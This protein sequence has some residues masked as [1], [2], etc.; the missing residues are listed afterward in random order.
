[1]RN[2]VPERILN[3]IKVNKLSDRFDCFS[4]F[5]D[6]SGFT[7]T[8]EALMK[9]GQEGAEVLSDILRYLFDTTVKA[10]YDHGGYVTKYAG[11]AFT[12]IFELKTGKGSVAANVLQAAL[13]TNNFFEENKIY[14]SRFGDFEFGVK[15]GIGYGECVCGIAGS[16]KEKT[17]YFSG[18]AVDLCAM[19]EHNAEKGQIWASESAF[20]DMREK[21]TEFSQSELY[22][23]KF[24]RIIKASFFQTDKSGYKPEVF[25]KELVYTMAGKKEAEFPVGEFRDVISVF[26]S[27]QGNA[28]LSSLMETV[29]KL[30]DMY[31]GSHP[32]LDFGDKGGNI[33]LFFGAP[34]SYENNSFRALSFIMRLRYSASGFDI[35]AGMARGIV[36]CGFNGSELRNEFTCL[37]NTV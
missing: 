10:V 12:A 14:S 2:L 16:D 27:F 23:L 33:L 22:G 17:Y 34:V 28:E 24:F 32:V 15:V 30:K 5:V 7:K 36:Y 6:I 31:G 1:M 8:T 9:H 13:I 19:A 37:G 18:S 35:R 21:V 11:D 25:D 4:M 29:Y 26:I 20:S 3:N